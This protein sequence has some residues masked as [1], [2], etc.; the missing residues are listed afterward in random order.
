MRRREM[1]SNNH[2]PVGTFCNP[3]ERRRGRRRERDTVCVRACECVRVCPPACVQRQRWINGIEFH[4]GTPLIFI[5]GV[6]LIT[7]DKVQQFSESIVSLRHSAWYRFNYFHHVK[8]T[9]LESFILVHNKQAPISHELRLK[10]PKTHSL[11]LFSYFSIKSFLY[12][13]S[14]IIS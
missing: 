4:D 6:V 5:Q 2:H 12:P 11:V 9:W 13:E 3:T 14:C 10:G 7:L 1:A 8:W